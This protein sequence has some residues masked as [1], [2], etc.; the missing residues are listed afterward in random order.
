MQCQLGERSKTLLNPFIH[1]PLR[2]SQLS[3]ATVMCSQGSVAGGMAPDV[4][5]VGLLSSQ[6][7]SPTLLPQPG[8]LGC[9]EV[10]AVDHVGIITC[11]ESGRVL[12]M[13]RLEKCYNPSCCSESG[14]LGHYPLAH[15]GCLHSWPSG[16]CWQTQR[17]QISLVPS[18]CM[19]TSRPSSTHQDATCCPCDLQSPQQSQ[20]PVSSKPRLKER[21]NTP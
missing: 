10:Q 12:H 3:S 17:K 11:P 5:P 4:L 1:V 9:A 19:L 2:S 15:S 21:R 6:G 7:L 20:C 8:A 16:L 18:C 13:R 14:F